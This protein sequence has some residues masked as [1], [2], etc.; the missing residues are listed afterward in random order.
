[1]KQIMRIYLYEGSDLANTMALLA[2]KNNGANDAEKLSIQDFESWYKCY[3]MQHPSLAARM[4][5]TAFPTSFN[6][7]YTNYNKETKCVLC[8]EIVDIMEINPVLA[9]MDENY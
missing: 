1:M 7:D 4:T 6:L 5:F 3:K 2:T 8:V 9:A